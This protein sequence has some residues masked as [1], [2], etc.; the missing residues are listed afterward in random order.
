MKEESPK[1]RTKNPGGSE[2]VSDW[3]ANHP[4]KHHNTRFIAV[5]LANMNVWVLLTMINVL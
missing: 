1:E 3:S 2:G 5:M 4:S